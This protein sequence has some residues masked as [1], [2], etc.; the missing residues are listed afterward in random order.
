M[1]AGLAKG[2]VTLALAALLDA[3]QSHP[4]MRGGRLVKTW[5]SHQGEVGEAAKPSTTEMP[6]VRLSALEG[7]SRTMCRRPGGGLSTISRVP[8]R[9]T[10]ELAVAGTDG[11]DLTDLWDQLHAILFGGTEADR[12]AF[13]DR[14][15][16][17]G[18]RDVVLVSPA[19][20]AESDQYGATAVAGAGELELVL[21]RLT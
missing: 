6:Y 21:F 17:A 9:V 16:R 13:W 15:S 8:V 1:I 12:T 5:R 10:V 3:L 4:T 14:M 19:L 20:P 2:P 18:V 11:A 7:A